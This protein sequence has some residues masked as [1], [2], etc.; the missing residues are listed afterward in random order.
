MIAKIVEFCVGIAGICFMLAIVFIVV[1]MGTAIIGSIILTI[2]LVTLCAVV[3]HE[4]FTG[5]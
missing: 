4:W 3:I 1:P 2:I 5:K